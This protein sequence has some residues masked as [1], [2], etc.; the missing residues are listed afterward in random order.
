MERNWSG[1]TWE[2]VTVEV[3][4]GV[5]TAQ[6]SSEYVWEEGAKPGTYDQVTVG[7]SVSADQ[8]V[9]ASSAA[10]YVV[11][12]Y[13]VVVMVVVV[14]SQLLRAAPVGTGSTPALRAERAVADST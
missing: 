4:V 9:A 2:A 10:A 1:E 8:V 3:D 14:A 11:V 12:V 7:A 6:A 13:V 5:G